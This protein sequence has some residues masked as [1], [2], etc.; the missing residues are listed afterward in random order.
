MRDN[1]RHRYVSLGI[2]SLPHRHKKSDVSLRSF[3]STQKT[4]PRKTPRHASTH[5]QK[6]H[7][8]LAAAALSWISP[9]PWNSTAVTTS[10]LPGNNHRVQVCS[11]ASP[12]SACTTVSEGEM[13]SHREAIVVG[14]GDH[15]IADRDN[16]RVRLCSSGVCST[17]AGT[18]AINGRWLNYPWSVAVDADG[19]YVIADAWNHRVVRC[20]PDSDCEEMVTGLSEPHH[21][22][23]HTSGDYLVTNTISH[24]ILLCP[25]SS[26]S[27]SSDCTT[28]AGGSGGSGSAQLD[29]PEAAAIDAN[30]DYAICDTGNDRIQLCPAAAPGADC[31][32]VAGTGFSCPMGI[33]V[34]NDMTSTSTSTNTTSSTSTTTNTSTASTS[35]TTTTSSTSDQYLNNEL[36]GDQH[37]QH[38]LCCR[39][40]PTRVLRQPAQQQ[41]QARR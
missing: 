29:S 36:H 5:V 35:S 30:G 21:V 31:V 16:H 41:L 4:T 40:R 13:K 1:G 3:F 6:H 38:E 8:L 33:A 17:V 2:Q 18:S 39:R 19:K 20:S 37:D 15:L 9:P 12:G 14:D 26:G 22:L 34:V 10:L 7:V 11:L 27:T 28:V 25:S 23:V 32:T 24:N